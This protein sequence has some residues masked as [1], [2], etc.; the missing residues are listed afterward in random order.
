MI[1][2][3]GDQINI[4]KFPNGESKIDIPKIRPRMNIVFKW[5]SD[6]DL[7]DLMMIKKYI[8][9]H[10]GTA[11]LTILYMPYSRMDRRIGNSVFTLKYV[12]D[13][14]NSLYFDSVTIYDPHSDVTPAIINKCNIYTIMPELMN[15]LINEIGIPDYIFYP[16]AGAQKRFKM[17]I[18][19]LVGFKDRDEET[20]RIT[21]YNVSGDLTSESSIVIVD[22]L[23]CYGGTFDLASQQLKDLGAGD[24]YL[25]VAHCEKAILEGNIFKSE[26]IKKVFTTNSI[27]D[28]SCSSERLNIYELYKM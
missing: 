22:D 7:I 25:V 8:D 11:N 13:F 15:G 9:D 18:P 6:N 2:I 14:I 27:I 10:N 4:I 19:G 28:K 3:D 23:C 16:D 26:N 5:E 20:G 21:K 1:L 24:I 17:E 12:A